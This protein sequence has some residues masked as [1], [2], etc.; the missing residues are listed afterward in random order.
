[1][2]HLSTEI[3]GGVAPGTGVLDAVAAVHPTPAVGGVPRGDAVDYIAAN[4]PLDRG[5]YTGGIGWLTPQG[6]GEIAIGLR[7]GLINRTTTTL[8]AGAGI[9]ADSE[10]G[11]EVRET[12]LK[13]R[14]LL[15][16]V[17]ST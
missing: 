4:E 5:W 7:C 14:P 16:L 8:F 6:D 12:R 13:L 11:A 2:Q 9:V 10:P 1:M 3:E 15:E 17:A